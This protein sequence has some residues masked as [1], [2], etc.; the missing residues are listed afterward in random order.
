M[1]PIEQNL[2][3]QTEKKAVGGFLPSY[4][5]LKT[6]FAVNTHEEHGVVVRAFGSY[7][8]GIRFESLSTHH[9]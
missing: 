8:G 7:W 3:N 5:V 9:C 1:T 2:F 4:W 6:Q